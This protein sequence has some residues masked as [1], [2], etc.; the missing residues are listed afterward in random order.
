MKTGDKILEYL[1][2][3]PELQVKQQNDGQYRLNHPIR[4]SSNSFDFMLDVNSDGEHGK[5]YDGA[6]EEGGSLYDLAK[7]LNIP[8]NGNNQLQTKKPYSGLDEYANQHHTPSK[9]FEDAGWKYTKN[10]H[11]NRPALSYPTNTGIRFRFIDGDKPI[12]LPAKRGYKRCWYLLPEAI[13]IAKENNYPLVICNGEPSCITGQYYNFAATCITGG[14]NGKIPKELLI[15]LVQSYQE[16]ILICYDNDSKG[17]ASAPKVAYQLR[18]EGY[19][20]KAL[21]L[22]GHKGYDLADFCGDNKWNALDK[23][24]QCDELPSYLQNPDFKPTHDELADRWRASSPLTAYGLGDW[25]RYDKGTWPT[26][27]EIIIKKEIKQHVVKA[28]Y[29]GIA[30][31]SSLVNS[32]MELAKIDIYQKDNIWDANPDY[33]VCKN[34]ALYIPDVELKPH[35]SLM[36]A[37]SG[38]DYNYNPFAESPN[39]EIFL[40]SIDPNIIYFLQEF[41]GYSLTIDTSYEI[42]VW[43]HGSPGGGK[44]TFLG[45]LQAMLGDRAGL[46][47]LGDIERS[48]F[49]LG[50]LPGKTL[51]VAT[52]QPN[53]YIKSSHIINALISG[54]PITVERKF[55]DP[56]DIY[57]RAKL[58]WAMNELPRVSDPNSGLFRRVKVIEFPSI[59]KENR[60]PNIKKGITNE[61]AGILNWAIEGLFRLKERGK[62]E[63]PYEIEKSTN[64]F[65]FYNDVPAV[66]VEECCVENLD[67]NNEPYK[68][69]ASDLYSAYKFW[70][71][72]SGLKPQGKIKIASDWKRLGYEQAKI[73]GTAYWRFIGLKEKL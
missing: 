50:S 17:K 67:S 32:T 64:Q 33:L 65:Q 18:Q 39:W 43:L 19:N 1:M 48:Q 49:A 60:N 34:G 21:E 4:D 41:A 73:N 31:T 28:K 63:V 30:P 12:F 53:S 10:T 66:F 36:Y 69:K 57:P 3:R 42:A 8:I 68:I 44:S 38:V 71:I 27:K 7:M 58:C 23:L 55:K 24:L 2:S 52:E 56:Y 35:S 11:Y 45:G 37:T 6:R 51:V 62:F 72:D 5:F 70:C 16:K 59:P 9:Q 54:E 29:E 26:I 14:E 13:K 25:R 20:A 22:K 15:Q 40:K 46:L 47:G 61:G